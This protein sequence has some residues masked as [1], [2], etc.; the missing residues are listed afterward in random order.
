MKVYI[1]VKTSRE[2]PGACIMGVF[3]NSEDAVIKADELFSG[4]EIANPALGLWATESCMLEL[5]EEEL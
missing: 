3:N 2:D 5:F 1:L 4:C